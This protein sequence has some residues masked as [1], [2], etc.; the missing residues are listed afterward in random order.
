M[1]RVLFAVAFLSLSISFNINA[2][3]RLAVLPLMGSGIEMSTQETTY[4]L[5]VS[6]IS[7]LKTYDVISKTEIE[8]LMG[9]AIARNCPALSKSAN[10][11]MLPKWFSG[12]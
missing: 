12:A 9:I 8:A 11:R 3:E 4:L 2:Q 6:E 7:K 10:R 1:K 5:L